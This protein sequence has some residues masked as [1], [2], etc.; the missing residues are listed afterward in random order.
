MKSTDLHTPAYRQLVKTT[1]LLIVMGLNGCSYIIGSATEDFT[2]NLKQTVLNHNDPDTVA[3][4]L[5]AYLIMLEASAT[6]DAENESLLFATANMYGAYISLLPDDEIRKQ[7]LS[8]KSL[9]FALQGGCLHDQNWCGLQQKSFDDLRS[10]IAQTDIDD[11]DSLYSISA[12]W[13]AWIQANKSDWNAIAQLA[14]VKLILKRVLELDETY[15]QGTA[16]VY[17]AVM[18][19]LI[20]ETLGGKPELAQQHFQRALQLAP[21][22]LMINV[23]YAKYYARMAFDRDLH[24]N[25][26]KKVLK[27]NV[28]APG[29]TLINTLAQQQAQQ[30]LD[31][32]ND[33]F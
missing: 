5:P 22:N 18:E 3:D 30:L 14:Q 13:T 33:Y 32:A 21:D 1:L 29:L 16:H 28:A 6:G 4:A 24:D 26:L 11:I 25:L 19:S 9:D 10:L 15:K 20:P 23:L 8:R 31:N 12:A 27:A 7:R 2:D 17:M